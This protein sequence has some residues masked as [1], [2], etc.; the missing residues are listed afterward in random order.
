M[1]KLWKYYN[2]NKIKVWTIILAIS[3][4]FIMLQVL[5]NAI[6]EERN[7]S[8]EDKEKETTS[9]VVSYNNES[10]SIITGGSVSNTYGTEIGEFINQFF[11]Y[12]INNETRKAYE[13]VSDDTKQLLYQTYELFEKNYCGTRFSGNKQFSFQSWSRSDGIYVY[14]VKIFD[15]MLATGKT[16]D[17]YIEEYVTIN[18]EGG[19]YKLNLNSYI[20]R[21]TLN[22]KNENDDLLVQ[23]MSVDRFLDYEIYTLSIQNKANE[24]ILLDTKRKS[25]TSYIT[26]NKG[27]KFEAMLYENSDEDLQFSPKEMKTIKIKYNDT[28]REG[29]LIKSINFTDIVKL[30]EFSADTTM[31]G[32]EF[33]IQLY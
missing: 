13:M 14:Q 17:D 27:N 22:V 12:C 29:M 2:Q 9:N 26:D 23:V 33:E 1:Y 15:N 19:S 8:N 20:G 6:K 21:K 30:D 3:I 11:T 16:N 31:Q 10:K 24:D 4:G 28:Y 32:Q 25:N 7:S 5:N 18:V